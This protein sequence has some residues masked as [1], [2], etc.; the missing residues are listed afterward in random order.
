MLVFKLQHRTCPIA[1]GQQGLTP[2]SFTRLCPAAQ[3]YSWQGIN[4]LELWAKVLGAHA[5]KAELRPLVY[6]LTQ[7]LLGA[8]R[9]VPTPRFFPLRLRLV[10]A[11]N[12]WVR[13]VEV[14]GGGVGR[15]LLRRT[16]ATDKAGVHG[17]LF[18]ACGGLSRS[19]AHVVVK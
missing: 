10:R 3:I 6:P 18:L 16:A 8:A 17:T 4:C 11:L 1:I 15:R 12:R 14:G 7:L 9:L 2:H 5:D 19:C 13:V